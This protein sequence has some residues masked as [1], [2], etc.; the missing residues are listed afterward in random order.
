MNDFDKDFYF[1]ARLKEGRRDYIRFCFDF[2]FT[3]R[4]ERIRIYE[5]YRF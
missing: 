1:E 3:N 4:K 5:V 2:R